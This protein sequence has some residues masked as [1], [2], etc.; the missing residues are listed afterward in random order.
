VRRDALE[1]P[2]QPAAHLGATGAT[3]SSDW[4]LRAAPCDRKQ[5]APSTAIPK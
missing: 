2:A 1:P 5:P 4:A 3:I